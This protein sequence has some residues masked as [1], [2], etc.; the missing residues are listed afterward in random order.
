MVTR[1][2]PLV[3]RAKASAEGPCGRY[4][5]KPIK[6]AKKTVLKVVKPTD[7]LGNLGIRAALF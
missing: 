2:L 4:N 7:G 5:G 6:T 1:I 3:F